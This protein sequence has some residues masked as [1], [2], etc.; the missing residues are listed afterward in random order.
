[1]KCHENPLHRIFSFEN[2]L[3]PVA[4]ESILYRPDGIKY[5]FLYVFGIRVARWNAN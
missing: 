2:V 1:M 4:V 5:K 3:I